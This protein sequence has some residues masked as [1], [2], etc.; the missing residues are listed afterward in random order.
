MAKG[1]PGKLS[2][3]H[4][5]QVL[6][7][8]AMGTGPRQIAMMLSQGI[9]TG[10]GETLPCVTATYQTVQYHVSKRADEVEEWR[11]KMFGELAT[12]VM[13]WPAFRL[14]E[15]HS[16]YRKCMEIAG[17]SKDPHKYFA[18]ASKILN[19]AGTQMA[20]LVPREGPKH[21]H[22][23]EANVNE[24]TSLTKE[25]GD[26][27]SELAGAGMLEEAVALLGGGKPIA[28]EAV[29]SSERKR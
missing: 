4:R 11:W 15:Q 14:K 23:H 3:Q 26:R 18:L 20:N 22:L 8:S 19:D 24:A 1:Y 5:D 10:S 17:R 6:R 25:L 7:H 2:A 28:T 29:A 27:L 13:S 9:E 21:V 16:I 12:E